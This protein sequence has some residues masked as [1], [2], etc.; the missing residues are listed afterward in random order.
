MKINTF[1]TLVLAVILAYIIF[2]NTIHNNIYSFIATL[3]ELTVIIYITCMNKYYGLLCCVILLY[4]KQI[5]TIERF[6]F[7]DLTQ[8]NQ[9][10]TQ[11][12]V[13]QIVSDM[14]QDIKQGPA[15]PP[16]PKGDP[17][18][19]TGEMG[20]QGPPGPQGEKGKKGI[21]GPSGYSHIDSNKRFDKNTGKRN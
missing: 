10:V 18:G 15:G 5:N 7:D 3:F 20:P 6:G 1:N 4:I 2:Y 14:I 11:D 9:P 8:N 12:K 17:G 13:R 19:P 21:Q 16:G